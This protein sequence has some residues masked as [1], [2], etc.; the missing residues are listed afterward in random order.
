MALFDLAAA[1]NWGFGGLIMSNLYA[2]RTT[3]PT[4]LLKAEDPLGPVVFSH[5]LQSR[6]DANLCVAAWGSGKYAELRPG[7]PAYVRKH[8]RECHVLC[9]NKDGSPHHPLYLKRD[10]KPVLWE[11]QC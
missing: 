4:D 9:L 8:L 11:S 2:F 3:Y 7:W 10:L 5:L 1:Q 6:R